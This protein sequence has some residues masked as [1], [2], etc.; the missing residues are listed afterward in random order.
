M[1]N[2]C[3]INANKTEEFGEMMIDMFNKGSLAL[4]VSIGHRT[5]LFDTMS[6]LIPSTCRD[7][8]A[9]AGLNERYVREWLAAMTVG[10]IVEY[11]PTTERYFLPT[12][13]TRM[14]TRASMADNMAVFAQ[15]M[16]VLGSV[17]DEVVACFRNGGGVPYSSYKR[18]NEVMAEDSGQT[19]LSSLIDKVLPVVPGLIDALQSGIEVLDI[20]CGSGRALN[21]MARTF[22]NS[23]FVGYDL[24]KEAVAVARSEANGNENVRFVARDLTGFDR[25]APLGRFDLVTAFDAIHDQARPDRVL[26]GIARALK[27]DGWFLMQDIGGSSRLED[28]KNI[29]LAPLLYTISCMHCMTVSLAQDG[30]GLGTMWG[31]ERAVE[32]LREAGF[33]TIDVRTLE[34]DII[35]Y[36]YVASK[37]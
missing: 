12:E 32:M 25:N 36:Y 28:N 8:A 19:A 7:I 2:T 31:K 26:A 20:G 5:G 13:H 14:L 1:C 23:R 11:D 15:Y 30:M 3:T 22:P 29:P 27:P 9:T 16:S 33:K 4:M 6:R 17:E 37:V 35:N 21:L 10:G 24:L 18:F 34:H